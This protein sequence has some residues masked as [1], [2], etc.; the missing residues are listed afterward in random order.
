MRERR[1]AR[2]GRGKRREGNRGKNR[3]T[4]GTMEGGK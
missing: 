2:M 1:R 4:G 3:R